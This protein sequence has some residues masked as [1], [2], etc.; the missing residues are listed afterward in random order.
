ME[1]ANGETK[2]RERE[3]EGGMREVGEKW[4]LIWSTCWDFNLWKKV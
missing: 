3:R 2:N 4:L 1:V